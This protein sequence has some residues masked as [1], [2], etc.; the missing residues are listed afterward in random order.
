MSDNDAKI[1]AD[2]FADIAKATGRINEVLGRRD[3]LNDSVP[4]FWPL[5]LS[6]DEFQLQ[7]LHVKQYNDD[8]AK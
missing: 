5:G 2:A 4:T 8:L 6:A 1:I 7:C 3:D